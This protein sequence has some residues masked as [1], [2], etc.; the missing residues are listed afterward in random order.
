MCEV[1]MPDDKT[2]HPSNSRATIPTI[3]NL[4]RF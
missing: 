4:V 2:P 1:M 3:P